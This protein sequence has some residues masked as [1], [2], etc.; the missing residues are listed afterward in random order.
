MAIGGTAML[1]H[2]T[3][4]MMGRKVERR[5]DATS[6][7][8]ETTQRC[9]GQSAHRTEG[10]AVGIW[11]RVRRW[12]QPR[13][14]RPDAA[15]GSALIDD[16]FFTL[17]DGWWGLHATSAN[18][19][20]TVTWRDGHWTE[21]ARGR[22]QFEPGAYRLYDR[23]TERICAEGRA[24][25]PHRGAVTN[26]GTFL[27]EEWGDPTQLASRVLAFDHGGRPLIEATF[28]ANV[29]LSGLSEE[30]RF[31][32]VQLANSDSVD[33]G[34]LLLL[35]LAR[36]ER[37][38]AVHPEAGWPHRY[39][40]D[41]ATGEV[42]AN[43]RGLG[44]FTYAADGHFRDADRMQNAKLRHGTARDIASVADAILQGPT[45]RV[46]HALEAVRAL[47]RALAQGLTDDPRERARS[48]KRLGQLHDALGDHSHAI[49]ADQEA[50]DCDAKVG[51]KRR[52]AALLK[53]QPDGAP[54]GSWRGVSPSGI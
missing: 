51:V 3:G 39:T 49:A 38:Y 53:E 29:A 15:P 1:E 16:L 47:T 17:D 18:G 7:T 8:I 34:R 33:G 10:G 14:Q 13:A 4:A 32:A 26:N 40:V 52:L 45:F 25:R 44:A 46:D 6:R 54:S 37:V 9:T 23:Q 12:L 48:L 22:R 42:T 24:P 11:A 28:S 19:R 43:M 27:L 50:C 36:G 31:A 41:D 30:G 20:W 5:S 2:P 21:S 35:D